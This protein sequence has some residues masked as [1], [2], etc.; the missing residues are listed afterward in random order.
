MNRCL[1]GDASEPMCVPLEGSWPSCARPGRVPRTEQRAPC[2]VSPWFPTHCLGLPASSPH[3]QEPGAST[4]RCSREAG[5]L[6]AS[7]REGSLL[8]AGLRC[9][10]TSTWAERSAGPRTRCPS[11]WTSLQPC[12]APFTR[13]TP[14]LSQAA[15]RASQPPRLPGCPFPPLTHRVQIRSFALLEF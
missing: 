10:R 15:R 12:S 1:G 3:C 8:M 5:I 13:Q 7:A 2:S 4:W 11:V 9:S 6:Q 14:G